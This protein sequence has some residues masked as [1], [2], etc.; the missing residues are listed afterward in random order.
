KGVGCEGTLTATPDSAT[1]SRA[2]RLQGDSIPALV[3]FSS[4]AGKP[5]GHDAQREARGMAVKLRLPDGA[6]SDILAVTTPAFV[7]RTPEDF[8]ELL[9]LRRPDPET[10]QPDFEKLGAFLAAHPE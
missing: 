6:E 5:D 2:A 10:G 7:A 3:R 4:G 8:L 1:L 9:R